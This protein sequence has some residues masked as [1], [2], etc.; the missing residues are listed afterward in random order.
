MSKTL[1]L[2]TAV[3]VVGAL[4]GCNS[5]STTTSGQAPQQEETVAST[6]VETTEATE[7]VTEEEP[8]ADEAGT[9][10]EGFGQ[11]EADED[12]SRMGSAP[13]S[14]QTQTATAQKAGWYM[15]TVVTAT[16]PDGKTY[17][18][19]SAGVFGELESSEER[20]DSHDIESYGSG[21]LQIKFVNLKI[22]IQKEYFSDYRDYTPE[23]EKRV[24][25]FYVKNEIG[26]DLSQADFTISVEPM[27][28]I[29]KKSGESRYYEG[30]AQNGEDKRNELILVDIDNQTTYSYAEAANH[31]FNMEGKKVRSFR[32]VLNGSVAEED[33]KKIRKIG[34]E[35]SRQSSTIAVPTASSKFGLPPM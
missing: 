30:R 20:R 3:M 27:R 26:E 23:D 11:S 6:P 25:A 16:T 15:R 18:H 5:Q 19:D 34:K 7:A 13:A 14:S 35:I 1:K 28:N 32:W 22:D 4:S 24:W 17:R 8:E 10:E 33:K 2:M 12:D 9:S 29:F 31:V 21:V